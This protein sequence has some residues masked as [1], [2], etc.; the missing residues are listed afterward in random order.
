MRIKIKVKSCNEEST[1]FL[2]YK[3]LTRKRN[4]TFQA[5]KLQVPF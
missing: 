2:N 5:R 3:I 4:I 1:P